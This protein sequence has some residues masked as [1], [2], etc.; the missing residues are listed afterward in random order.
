ME[1]D[2]FQMRDSIASCVEGLVRGFKEDFDIEPTVRRET[3]ARE[4]IQEW[5]WTDNFDNEIVVTITVYKP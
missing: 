2:A 4:D 1:A 5:I 3:N